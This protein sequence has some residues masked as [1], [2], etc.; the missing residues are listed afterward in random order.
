MTA[1]R[2]A[3]KQSSASDTDDSEVDDLLRSTQK[4]KGKQRERHPIKP[5]YL[6]GSWWAQLFT[7]PQ[8]IIFALAGL[9]GMANYAR[10]IVRIAPKRPGLLKVRSRPDGEGEQQ[11]VGQW[12]NENVPSLKKSF[13]PSWWLPK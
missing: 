7:V 5:F 9:L 1:R 13:K 2:R 3:E 8:Q 10:Q 11:D 12:I 6:P 4:G